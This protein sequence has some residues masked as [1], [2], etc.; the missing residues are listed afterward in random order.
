MWEA[1]RPQRRAGGLARLVFAEAPF[2]YRDSYFGG[3][4]FL[5]QEVVWNGDV[6]AWAMSYYGYIPRPDLIDP[7]RAGATIKAGLRALR[8]EGRFLG[9]F[10]WSSPDGA[11]RD[12]IDGRHVAF[13]R[14]RV[15]HRRRRRSVRARLLRRAQP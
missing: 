2:T 3:T 10:E 8:C 1:E 7:T 6:P 14:A 9:G 11:Y 13:R 15:H 5:G 4:D 12:Q